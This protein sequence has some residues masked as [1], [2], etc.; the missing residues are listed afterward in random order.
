MERRSAA[1]RGVRVPWHAIF[2]VALMYPISTVAGTLIFGC[3]CVV[4]VGVRSSG[5]REDVHTV[6]THHVHACRHLGPVTGRLFM[7]EQNPIRVYTNTA[8]K[9]LT[10]EPGEGRDAMRGSGSYNSYT[11]CA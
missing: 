7:A 10:G 3:V 1:P 5:G 8:G 4:R 9:G 11:R 2:H 6:S